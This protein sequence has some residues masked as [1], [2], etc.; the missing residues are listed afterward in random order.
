MEFDLIMEL[1]DNKNSVSVITACKNRVK[2]LKV[3]LASWLTFDEVKEVI[4]VDWNSDDPINYLTKLDPRVKV[5]RVD[6][7]EHFNQPQPLN[8]AASIATGEFIVKVDADH[9]FN[10]YDDVLKNHCPSDEEFFCGQL[11]TDNPVEQWRNEAGDACINV[12]QDKEDFRQYLLTYNSF[13]RYLVG[14]L[15]VSKKHF[16]AVGGYNEKLGDC[17]AYED[18]EMCQRLEV[19]GL[20]KNKY[21]VNSYE[22]IHLPHGDN[23]RI[24]NFKGFE[25]QEYYENCCYEKNKQ[26]YSGD[27]LKWQIEYALSEKHTEVNKHMIGE[28]LDYKVDNKTE[29]K[30]SNIDDQNYYAVDVTESEEITLKHENLSSLPMIRFISLEE[31][32]DRREE[33][34]NV[35]KSNGIS[36]KCYVSKRFHECNYKITGKYADTL[37]DGTKGCVVSHLEMIKDWYDNTDEDYGFFAEDDLSLETVQYWDFTWEDFISNTPE[38][39]DCIQLLS[40]RDKFP[41]MQIRGRYWDDWGATAYIITRDYAAKIIDTYI[42]EDEY[43]LEIPGSSIQPLVENLI[44]TLG[45]TYT[46]PLFVENIKFSSTFENRDDDVEDGGKNNHVIAAKKVLDWWK[47]KNTPQQKSELEDLIHQ[48][49]IDTENPETNF[50]LAYYYYDQGHTAPALS[51]FLRCAERGKD[52]HPDLAY[53]ALIMGSYCY[54]KQGTRDQSGRGLLWQAQM[55]LPK[56]PEAYFLLARYAEKMQWWQD[57]YSTA[58]LC[59][60]VCDFNLEKLPI[61]VE[62]P[63]KWGIIYEKSLASWWWGKESETRQLVRKIRDDHHEDIQNKEH[64][65]AIQDTLIRLA[66]GYISEEEL[67]YD[68]NRNQKLRFKFDGWEYVDKNYSQAFQDLFVLSALNGK[69]RGLYLEIGAQQ[70]F[71]QNNTALLETKFG[72]DGISIEIRQDLCDQFFRERDNK[73]LCADAL[74]VD[75]D[76]LLTKFDKGT[77]FDYL[78]VDCEP[79]ETTYQILTKIPFEKYKFALITYEHDDYVD[80]SNKY[81]K[82]S[83]DYLHSKG[84]KMLVSDVSLNE[85]SSFEDWWYHPELIDPSIVENMQRLDQIVDVRS[86]MIEV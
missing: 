78:Q 11:K 39:A 69:K 80:L 26:F 63:G 31:S 34:I 9:T 40:I 77:V 6:D 50:N 82:L 66:T 70:P 83:R 62:Y 28:V 8:L 37:N 84:Y 1:K 64:F 41:T 85:N 51:Y 3:S 13:Y 44:F 55:F 59:L 68:K 47:T 81:K 29:W 4:I 15:Y 22:F 76:K 30:I 57:C 19:Y 71:Y 23:K 36:S 67:K 27:V 32:K 52:T 21:H 25:G 48:Y 73:I 7:K 86:Y 18:D 38:D 58:E 2:A 53:T 24:E 45:K 61:D 79:S 20:K 5:V 49:S 33:L 60:M 75:Y 74:T 17:Y 54:F 16:D 14:I 35:F 72:W 42:K 12:N 56:R 10:P 65:K 43:H 46:I